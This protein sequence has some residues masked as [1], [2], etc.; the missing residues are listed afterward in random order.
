MRLP[1]YELPPLT[2]GEPYPWPTAVSG[3]E[4]SGSPYGWPH[5][6]ASSGCPYPVLMQRPAPM[7]AISGCL[8]P[9]AVV[10]DAFAHRMGHNYEAIAGYLD[11]KV[12][13][14]IAGGSLWEEGITGS[15]FGSIARSVSN[16]ARSVARVATAP[17]THAAS[18]LIQGVRKYNPVAI[19]KVAAIKAKALAGSIKDSVAFHVLR[20]VT[21]K[22]FAPA[23]AIIKTASHVLPYAQTV[24]SFV[25]GLGSGVSAALGAAQAL[26]DGKSISNIAVAAVRGAIPGGPLAQAAFDTVWNVANG[27]SIDTAVLG[28][29]R[30]RLPGGELAKRAADT[31]LALAAAKTAQERRRL[32][33]GAAVQALASQ[34]SRVP[35]IPKVPALANLPGL[36][37]FV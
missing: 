18:A 20:T 34:A 35:G 27:K 16:A 17:V 14:M 28:A 6:F 11:A 36:P 9:M 30:E 37:R 10:G 22:A 31:A 1:T 3:C 19:A 12:G 32:L 2:S 8:D 24:V 33:Q 13:E 29:L 7:A 26:A 4:A 21:E 23:M 25:P 15:I 5:P